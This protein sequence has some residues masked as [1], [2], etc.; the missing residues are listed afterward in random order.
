MDIQLNN[1]VFDQMTA[2]R[3]YT[4][5]KAGLGCDDGASLQSN[6][7]VWVGRDSVKLKMANGQKISLWLFHLST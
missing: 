4:R 2:G 5:Q 6:P 7:L 1:N 3:D